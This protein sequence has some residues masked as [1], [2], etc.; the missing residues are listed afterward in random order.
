MRLTPLII[1][2]TAT[3]GLIYALNKPWGKT[4]AIGMLL[5]PQNGLWQNA[6]NINEDYN[7]TIKLPNLKVKKVQSGWAHTFIIYGNNKI[8]LLKYFIFYFREW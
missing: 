7:N 5:S 6:E 4:P 8:L 2:A 1:S 3:I